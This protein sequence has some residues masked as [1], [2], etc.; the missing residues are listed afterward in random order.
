MAIKAFDINLNNVELTSNY[1]QIA[2]LKNDRTSK[3]TKIEIMQPEDVD[4][5]IAAY[6]K[7]ECRTK[8]KN[9]SAQVAPEPLRKRKKHF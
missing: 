1:I 2:T 9:R 8:Y 5:V 4:A 7:G 3:K 6:K